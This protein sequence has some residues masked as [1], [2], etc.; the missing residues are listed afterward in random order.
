MSQLFPA[1]YNAS[2]LSS[3]NAYKTKQTKKSE[4]ELTA[5]VLKRKKINNTQ[6]VK[7]NEAN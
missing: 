7:Q 3:L 5:G 1:T 6:K 2:S 4:T